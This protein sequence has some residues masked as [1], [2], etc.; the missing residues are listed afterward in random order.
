MMTDSTAPGSARRAIHWV[1]LLLLAT[2]FHQ[3]ADAAGCGDVVARWGDVTT[4]EAEVQRRE[5]QVELDDLMV[6][7]RRAQWADDQTSKMLQLA[8]GTALDALVEAHLAAEAR[9]AG[10]SLPPE[11]EAKIRELGMQ[12]DLEA[13][14]RFCE[15]RLA[16][17]PARLRQMVDESIDQAEGKTVPSDIVTV[18]L[19]WRQTTPETAASEKQQLEELRT[20]LTAGEI[21]PSDAA[22]SFSRAPSAFSGGELPPS[23]EVALPPSIRDHV[24]ALRTGEWSPVV[25]SKSSAFMVQLVKRE[26]Y[27]EAVISPLRAAAMQDAR[28]AFIEE[29]ARE[30]V[31]VGT[32]D[33]E[34]LKQLRQAIEAGRVPQPPPTG[35][36]MEA[37]LIDKDLA[38]QYLTTLARARFDSMSTDEQV[39]F[40]EPYRRFYPRMWDLTRRDYRLRRLD[41]VEVSNQYTP[42]ELRNLWTTDLLPKLAGLPVGTTTAAPVPPGWELVVRE[43]T[44]SFLSKPGMTPDKRVEDPVWD[45]GTLY[46]ESYVDL[47]RGGKAEHADEPY[48]RLDELDEEAR[49]GRMLDELRA[50]IRAELTADARANTAWTGALREIPVLPA[51]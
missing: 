30:I 33:A 44:L 14:G 46:G 21:S 17:E 27:Q 35:A 29:V 19:I 20:R 26:G 18:R 15:T 37:A 1:T 42:D 22:R 24:R 25:S 2:S 23:A 9:R 43:R 38:E 40:F 39:R 11:R 47:R 48:L 5:S 49:A 28:F 41:S 7:L 36:C 31:G 32:K 50:A 16:A 6:T 45:A 51:P 4:T 10:E 12:R 3:A 13:W 8:R 34:F